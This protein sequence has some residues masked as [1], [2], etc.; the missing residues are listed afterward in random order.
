VDIEDGR[1]SNVRGDPEN[2]L[3]RGYI[4]S[5]GR[6]SPAIHHGENRLVQSLARGVDGD[7]HPVDNGQ[8][9]DEIAQKLNRIRDE[10]GPDAIAL[11]I[12]TYALF[13]TLTPALA[14]GWLKGIESNS[15]YTT[16]TI[17]Q[18]AKW[19]VPLRMGRW[20]GGWQT[21]EESD[22]W[23]LNGTNPLVSMQGGGTLTG[24]PAYDPVRRL[25]EARD[26][27]LKLI[28]IDPRRTETARH[29]DLFLQPRP[30]HDAEIFAAMIH[31]IL[32]EGLEDRD[33]CDRYVG[34]LDGLRRAM[35]A[36]DPVSVA[37]R[38][39]LSAEDL[40]SAA[41]MF[42]A[43]SR[44]MAH[45]GT[46]PDMGPHSNLAE[47]MIATLNVICGRYARAGDKIA[48][49]GVLRNQP[50]RREGVLAPDRQWEAG[51]KSRTGGY[52]AL[53]GERPTTSLPDQILD[54][55]PGRLRALVVV[56]GNPVACWPDQAR[57]LEALRELDLLIVLDPR[58]T[59]TAALANYVIAPTLPFERPDH[60]AWYEM[61]FP[62]PHAQ[63]TEALLDPP[64]GTMDDWR[65]FYELSARM[66]ADIPFADGVLRT[67]GTPPAAN[68]LLER[69]AGQAR[70]PYGEI[71][72]ASHGRMFDFDDRVQPA[73]ENTARFE[74]LPVDVAGELDALSKK[75]ETCS[76][77]K[78][79]FRL[80]CRRVRWMMN[81]YDGSWKSVRRSLPEP[82]A[83]ANPADLEVLGIR[84]GDWARITSA[85]GE[86]EA[87]M[88]P[89]E[90][91]R[92]G[93]IS[94]PHCQDEASTARL[95]DSAK[96]ETIN[97]MPVMSAIP[98]RVDP[99]EDEE[100]MENPIE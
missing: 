27:G 98:V 8:A 19:I 75:P 70:V 42:G 91:V 50:V 52:G 95:V 61:I 43:A 9:L 82:S 64:A 100:S 74:L 71:L 94:M 83:W 12:G 26:R 5:K 78:Y 69:L 14:R 59:R 72:E 15:L 33:F 7:F 73:D 96:R 76:R 49:P 45:G 4:C 13:A 68:E 39:G 23:L 65:F 85:A 41:R 57:S 25:K 31:V 99:V 3:S 84:D 93:V 80:V 37:A 6:E 55:G 38:A 77:D 16:G 58:M 20:L 86:I 48:N 62:Y 92:P 30:G 32:K 56:G 47:H 51:A 87:I 66:G 46:G 10:D 88:R 44:G 34:P 81:S 1:I 53:W 17:D 28:V 11:F 60:T 63:Y 89:D 2:P 24:F 36:F 97:A 21:F 35:E 18:S 40:T 79:P 54:R 22:I 90:A 29:A 67:N